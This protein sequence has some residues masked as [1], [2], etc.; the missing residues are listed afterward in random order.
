MKY[1]IVIFNLFVSALLLGQSQ[2]KQ[3]LFLGNSYTGYF[4][5]PQIIA[6]IATSTDDFLIFDSNTPGGYTLENHYSDSISLA[7]IAS[8]NWDFVV[9]QEQS[10]RPA[11][12]ISDV[13]SNVFPYAHLLDSL[14]NTQNAGAETVFYQTWGRKNGDGDN[15]GTWPPVCTYAGMDS[16]LRLRYTML[17]ER[18]DAILSPV[19]D[20]WNKLRQDFPSLDLY[21]ADESHPSN[22][23][24]YAAACTFYTI[25]FRKNPTTIT[26]DFTLTPENAAI[27]RATTKEV[28]YDRLVNNAIE[29][30]DK[31]NIGLKIYPNPVESHLIFEI[32]QIANYRYKIVDNQGIEA[33]RGLSIPNDKQI[34]VAKL[35]SGI[36]FLTILEGD[37]IISVAKFT[38]L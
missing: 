31:K 10:Q 19:G 32:N 38:K 24:S 23:G 11:L 26:F 16:L 6:D 3:I 17:A 8:S 28:V 33:L 13:E 21:D 18:N 22:A 20:V 2:T 4:N 12:P 14:I 36:Y 37:K 25:I 7:K 29:I 9:L 34:L 30:K 27:I 35:T 1:V 5:L 15:C